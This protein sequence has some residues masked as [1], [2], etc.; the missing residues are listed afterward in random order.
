[1]ARPRHRWH[2]VA[3]PPQ[4]LVRPSRVDPQG[5]DGPTK[6]QSEGRFWV[7][8]SHGW[9]VPVTAPRHLPEQRI[10]EQSVRLGSHGGVT[11]WAACR[12][13]GA[14]F[15]DG[16]A[17]DGAT[18]L[19]VPL[20]VGPQGHLASSRHSFPLHHVLL[21][22]DRTTRFGIPTVV[23]ERAAYDAIRLAPDCTARI[24]AADMALAGQITSIPLL[25]E[26]AERQPQHRRLVLAVLAAASEH[27]RSPRETELRVVAETEAGMSGLLVNPWLYDLHGT[28][29]GI[30]D[31][32]DVAAGVAL[33]LEGADH[34]GGVQRAAD[35]R[36]AGRFHEVGL[37]VCRVV[38]HETSHPRMVGA[39]IRQTQ[40]RAA[41][42]PA[43]ERRW[44]AVPRDDDLHDLVMQRRLG[45]APGA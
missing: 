31:L 41:A 23:P 17:R 36:R 4:G 14:S 21:P 3:L 45:L 13:W 15:F 1:M 26:Y 40:A 39:R 10:L 7:R 43:S 6:K 20:N 16:L 8:T 34:D 9:H 28:L 27:S 38:G 12:L 29:L 11:A 33:E 19:R 35:H 25:T 2:P 24:V 42:I 30:P 44:V 18:W 32:L 5:L 37:E 22:G